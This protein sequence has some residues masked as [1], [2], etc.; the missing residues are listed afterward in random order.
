MKIKLERPIV[1]FDLETTGL[2]I[3]KDRIIEISMIK[4]NTDGTKDK[5]YSLVEP[6]GYP[7]S[8]G[9][10]EKH[11]YSNEDLLGHPKFKDIAKD[12]YEFV[13]DCDLGGYNAKRFDIQILVDELLRAGIF[14]NSRKANVI[15]AFIIY[16]KME[17]R[18]LEGAYRYYT[19]NVLED[20]HSADADI[21]ATLEIF[22]KQIEKY[23]ELPDTI[24]G[25][26]NLTIEDREKTVDLAG[27]FIQ[28]D[29]KDILF[30]FG[31][32]KGMTVYEVFKKDPSYFMW[33]I[34]KT[35]M[36]LETKYIANKIYKKLREKQG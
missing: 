28:D 29:N 1:F 31:K 14:L 26:S 9:A 20:A 12:V 33:M 24:E 21:E 19:G 36:P 2:T 32:Y 11:G 4:L 13:K 17:P 35:D 8:D 7:V 23:D 30:N 27:R 34:E 10:R 22:E 25:I 6:D 18:N 3:G 16:S 15:D 5:Y